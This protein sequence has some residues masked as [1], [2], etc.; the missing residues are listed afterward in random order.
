LAFVAQKDRCVEIRSKKRRLSKAEEIAWQYYLL[1]KTTMADR[2]VSSIYVIPLDDLLGSESSDAVDRFK[3]GMGSL[4]QDEGLEAVI[5]DSR[6][7]SI[8]HRDELTWLVDRCN[9]DAEMSKKPKE[10]VDKLYFQLRRAPT[11]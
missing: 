8:R 5:L 3:R 9:Q 4:A 6:D 10:Y 2:N 1:A 7:L 11:C